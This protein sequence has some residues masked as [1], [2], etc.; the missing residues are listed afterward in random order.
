MISFSRSTIRRSATLWTRPAESLGWIF[1]QR[2]GESSNPTR[3]SST[4]R[5]C[6]ASTRFMSISL[7]FSMAS[8]IAVFVISLKTM[9]R[10][11]SLG[12]SRVWVRCHEMASPSRSPSEAS[13]MVEAASASLR[14][15]AT[16]FFLSAGMTYSGLKPFSTSTPS[17]CSSRSLIWPIDAFTRKSFP[18]YF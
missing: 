6:W 10:V 5:A 17:L 3:R 15:S 11:F 12:R 8:R 18:R 4:R 2:M 1:F 13:Q 7:G 9:R 16:T 14:R